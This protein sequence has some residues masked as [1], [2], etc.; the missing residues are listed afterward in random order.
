MASGFRLGG[1]EP[2]ETQRPGLPSQ[3]LRTW[4]IASHWSGVSRK[5]QRPAAPANS[6]TPTHQL[7]LDSFW[8][9]PSVGVS[10]RLEREARS[11]PRTFRAG[12]SGSKRSKASFRYLS[13][14]RSKSPVRSSDC[15]RRLRP[16]RRRQHRRSCRLSS[17]R[18]SLRPAARR[19]SLSQFSGQHIFSTED[20][21]DGVATSFNPQPASGGIRRNH[22]QVVEYRAR[23]LTNPETL[24]QPGRVAARQSIGDQSGTLRRLLGVR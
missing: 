18:K 9:T 24:H 19:R 8:G 13:G 17:S 12:H 23:R 11:S 14:R 10:S 4:P 5:L 2:L 6:S 3:R 1:P 21:K 22:I 15:R 16:T 20:T 7:I